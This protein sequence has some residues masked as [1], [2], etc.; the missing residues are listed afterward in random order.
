MFA[1]AGAEVSVDFLTID[2]KLPMI[3]TQSIILQRSDHSCALSNT[4]ISF[5]QLICTSERFGVF[6][7]TSGELN[8]FN[9]SVNG[10]IDV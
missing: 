6:G 8:I 9:V 7:F 3:N 5:S 4:V 1:Q 2:Y 10:T